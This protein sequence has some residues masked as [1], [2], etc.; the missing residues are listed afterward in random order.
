M[1]NDKVMKRVSV[2]VGVIV[3]VAA[4]ACAWAYFISNDPG[5]RGEVADGDYYRPSR[6]EVPK[7]TVICAARDIAAGALIAPGD[8]EEQSVPESK[9]P[10]S[11]IVSPSLAV[12]SHAAVNIAGGTIIL[13]GHLKHASL[14]PVM[15][16]P[17]SGP[18]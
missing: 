3:L 17:K 14:A 11:A 4:G 9:I 8:L 1:K 13:A 6:S 7:V 2:V 5:G 12:G 18:K 10:E 16:D 15:R